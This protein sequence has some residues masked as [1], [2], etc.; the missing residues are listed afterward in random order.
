MRSKERKIIVLS[1]LKSSNFEQAFFVLKDGC[2]ESRSA[3]F[4]AERIVEEYIFPSSPPPTPR[5]RRNR[6]LDFLPFAVTAAVAI[7]AGAA[8]IVVNII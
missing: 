5:R 6:D 1:N 2:E 8:A 3:V 7:L 4:E